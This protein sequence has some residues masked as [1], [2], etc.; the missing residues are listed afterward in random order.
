MANW[1][2][3][4][5]SQE[6]VAGQANIE[7]AYHALALGDSEAA[8][9][10][11]IIAQRGNLTLWEPLLEAVAQAPI[12]LMPDDVER[13]AYNALACAEQHHDIQD[14]VKAIILCT[15]LLKAFIGTPEQWA[16]T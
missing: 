3:P 14:A 4:S 5:P 15:W 1:Q 8:I 11:G 13:Q 10:L 6:I 16:G 9:V 2:I 7:E 12:K